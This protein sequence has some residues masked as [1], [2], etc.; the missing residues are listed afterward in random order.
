[1]DIIS[2]YLKRTPGIKTVMVKYN[3]EWIIWKRLHSCF[4]FNFSERQELQQQSDELRK[5][6]SYKCYFC[7]LLYHIA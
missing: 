7:C 6:V 3:R 1:M 2:F 5:D 4:R